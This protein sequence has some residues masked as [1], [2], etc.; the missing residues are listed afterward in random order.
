MRPCL[1]RCLISSHRI[2]F[3]LAPTRSDVLSD[4]EID[5]ITICSFV[6]MSSDIHYI[7]P[8]A[9]SYKLLT[10]FT[11][12]NE[13][14][15]VWAISFQ[16]KHGQFVNASLSV[17]FTLVFAWLWGLIAAAT[18]YL[19]PHR[20]SRR[21][22][23]ALVALRNSSEPW[24]A[25][26]AFMTFTAD[27]M[28][29]C[30][31]RPRRTKSESTP[32]TRSDTRFGFML[33][34]LALIVV[35]SS[36][37]MGVVGPPLLQLGPVAPVNPNI[38]YYPS[39]SLIQGNSTAEA[40]FRAIRSE[41]AIRALSSVQTSRNA[42]RRRVR[43]DPDT[44]FNTNAGD[45][46]LRYGLTYSYII[47][48]PEFGLRSAPDL[49]LS[50]SGGCRTEYGW[51]N[52]TN[53]PG[54]EQYNLLGATFR[55]E[56]Q[57]AALRYAPK[58][59]FRLHADT[60][61]RNDQQR[62]GNV[63]YAIMATLANRTSITLNN[64]D[65]WYRT[66]EV[67]EFN[68]A[69]GRN[70]TQ[71]RIRTSRPALSCWQADTWTCC[72][73]QVMKGHATIANLASLGLE[74]PAVLLQVIGL[75]LLQPL[76]MQ[77]GSFAGTAALASVVATSSVVDGVL[78]AGRSSIFTDMERLI[79]GS[80]I[81]ARNLL[82]ETA[83]HGNET[84]SQ[85]MITTNFFREKDSGQLREG[86]GDFV[87]RSPDV[88]AFN[89]AG[90]VAMST[91]SILLLIVKVV[92]VL[93]LF[94]FSNNPHALPGGRSH[95]DIS[96]MMDPHLQMD[97]QPEPFNNDRWARFKV[98]SA[99]HLLRNTYE[100]G[101]GV[102]DKDWM[103]SEEL[104]EP[105]DKKPLRLVQCKHGDA[106]CAG[107]IATDP[108]LLRVATD[109][110]LPRGA[111]ARKRSP[112]S[113]NHDSMMTFN[114]EA[115]LFNPGYQVTPRGPTGYGPVRQD[116]PRSPYAPSSG[117]IDA[118]MNQNTGYFGAA[119]YANTA[120]LPQQT[121]PLESPLSVSSSLQSPPPFQSSPPQPQPPLNPSRGYF[122]AQPPAE[123][124][125]YRDEIPLQSPLL[126][127]P[128]QYNNNR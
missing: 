64:F 124:G 119:A 60:S 49:Q 104:P 91:I 76:P 66:D 80:Y 67:T 108:G 29:C 77:I 126:G 48:G 24:S 125:P 127:N 63:S 13:N 69:A 52:L 83:L 116:D 81:S 102:A 109:P 123:G 32:S 34:L 23:V 9:D 38:L 53:T 42:I 50:V 6:N 26:W 56:T 112:T 44:A 89:M 115:P 57:G 40:K 8:P 96:E 19:A 35:I 62:A 1:P 110:G 17:V 45:E 87:I 15:T 65:P 37:V 58:C 41:A 101:T 14:G 27:S 25:F 121:P 5:I 85:E 78:D 100:D 3:L 4:T 39:A 12:S 16:A 122:Q 90:L 98:F 51:R 31:P 73:G 61:V 106:G 97:H 43:I 93:K 54:V 22:L 21:R 105:S 88:A 71:N 79:L 18:I 11:L 118:T 10:P 47:T 111:A 92:L 99:V 2:A 28:G 95:E 120:P 128:T 75:N 103:C 7:A 59:G 70:Q 74:V 114:S 68:P 94:F 30:R 113:V 36:V 107:H 20:F 117:S 82:T 84:G 86:A 46:E 72:G 33:V 55:V